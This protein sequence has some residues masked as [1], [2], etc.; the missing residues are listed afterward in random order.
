MAALMADGI[1]VKPKVW[2]Q[3]LGAAEMFLRQ[4]RN[5]KGGLCGD[6]QTQ[7]SATTSISNLQQVLDLSFD[8]KK[9]ATLFA[10]LKNTLD[11]KE[12][13]EFIMRE[14]ALTKGSQEYNSFL[15]DLET[16]KSH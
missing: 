15:K 12:T 1:K 2:M 10:S 6:T 8:K 14:S 5:I 3:S 13:V 16:F 11:N 4:S 7:T 9:D